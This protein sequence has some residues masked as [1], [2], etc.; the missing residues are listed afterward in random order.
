MDPISQ[1][2]GLYRLYGSGYQIIVPIT[3]ST[4]INGGPY[5]SNHLKVTRDEDEI[6]LEINDVELGTWTDNNIIGETSMGI[7]STPFMGAGDPTSDAWFD[8]FSVTNL[9]NNSVTEME[10]GETMNLET[11]SYKVI[12]RHS[13]SHPFDMKRSPPP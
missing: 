12:K 3:F 2:F 8:N 4:S 5:S 7:F 10:L 9:Q 1:V 6:T 11:S 13:I